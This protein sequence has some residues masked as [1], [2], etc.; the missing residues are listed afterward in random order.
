[1]CTADGVCGKKDFSTRP[2]GRL[3][4]S[5]H[6]LLTKGYSYRHS[7]STR[8]I[9]KNGIT[10]ESGILNKEIG[11]GLEGYVTCGIA[12]GP[13]WDAEG[14]VSTE[15]EA[16][17]RMRLRQLKDG[18]SFS[19]DFDS[20]GDAGV[21]FEY[22]D[23]ASVVSTVFRTN[24]KR[25]VFQ[26]SLGLNGSYQIQKDFSV[27]AQAQV[28]S[29]GVLEDIN[30]AIEYETGPT[31]ITL[32]TADKFNKVILSDFAKVTPTIDVGGSLEVVAQ[33]PRQSEY[34]LS[35]ASEYRVDRDTSAKIKVDSHGMV[36]TAVDYRLFNPLLRFGISTSM[37]VRKGRPETKQF[38]LALQFGDYSFD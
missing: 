5:I 6:D 36:S 18:T 23:V 16:S 29:S 25:P 30:A 12:P 37:D 35:L 33:G 31:T 32:S 11:T 4:S 21:G 15:N 19:F 38:G 17:A 34:Q 13:S 7:I 9:N 24:L 14:K 28:H 8:K 27:G 3:G 22:Q 2:F 20:F 10:L 1:M 26:G